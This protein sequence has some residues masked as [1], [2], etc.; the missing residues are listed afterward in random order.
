MNKPNSYWTKIGY[1]EDL[2]NAAYGQ[3]GEIHFQPPYI[4]C[5]GTVPKHT[6]K[7]FDQF[8]AFLVLRN[9][10]C[11]VWQLKGYR[12]APKPG[13][14]FTLDIH[15]AH[16]VTAKS[17]HALVLLCADGKT[18]EQAEGNLEKIIDEIQRDIR[19]ASLFATRSE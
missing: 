4:A 13:E 3:P 12:R 18:K 15:R 1:P 14:R 16:G 5:A 2:L 17:R 7:D 9:D 11:T 6:D 10:G 19:V 8:S